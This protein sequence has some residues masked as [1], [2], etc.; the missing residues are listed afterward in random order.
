MKLLMIIRFFFTSDNSQLRKSLFFPLIGIFLATFIILITFSIMDGMQGKIEEKIV[1]FEYP[2]LVKN[3]NLNKVNNKNFSNCGTSKISLLNNSNLVK[4]KIYNN[5]DDYVS[6][7]E[8]YI[9]VSK[10]IESNSIFIGSNLANN[11]NLNIG[12]SLELSA[13]TDVNYITGSIQ[14]KD[15][16]VSGIFK[17]NFMNFDDDFCIISYDSASKLF[18]LDGFVDFYFLNQKAALNFTSLNKI[19]QDSLISYKDIYYDLLTAIEIEKIFY[20]LIGYFTVLIAG[21]MIYNNSILTYLEKRRQYSILSIIGL[22]KRKI[23]YGILINN[24]F[25]V[26]IFYFFGLLFSLL[27]VFL[28]SKYEIMNLVFIN[29]PF[30]KLP[31]SISVFRILESLIFVILVINFSVLFPYFKYRNNDLHLESK[32]VN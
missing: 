22:N 4:V 8:E 13:I 11:L 31:M 17:F 12:D 27:V 26:L 23:L 2:Y 10:K 16:I 20:V 21:V 7:I 6:N 25:L 9:S 1:K 15:F 3:Y 14:K 18:K 29:M 24:N 32:E 30:D 19:N 5:F 28:N